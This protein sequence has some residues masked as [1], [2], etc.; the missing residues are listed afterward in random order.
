MAKIAAVVLLFNPSEEVF[1]H[2]ESYQTETDHV[3][4]IDNTENISLSTSIKAKLL[5][6]SN[7]SLLHEGENLGIAKALNLALKQAKNDGYEWLLTMDQDSFFDKVALLTYFKHFSELKYENVA[8]IAPLHNPKFVNISLEDPYVKKEV[9][10][11]SGNLVKVK[12]ALSIGAY[13]EALFIDEVDHAFCFELQRHDYVI[14]Q[15]QTVFLNHM[16]GRAFGKY[17]NIKLY[18]SLRLYYM[19]RNYFY[20]KDKYEAEFSTFFRQRRRY[21]VKFFMKQLLFGKNRT[22]KIRMILEGYLDYKNATYGK[23]NEK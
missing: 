19:L 22:K 6:H 1:F 8:L 2:I 23:Y 7:T 16:L 14:L 11:S 12:C 10:L 9:V 15:D 21:F 13:D 4:L 3:Y 5:A 20:L 18:P 17:G